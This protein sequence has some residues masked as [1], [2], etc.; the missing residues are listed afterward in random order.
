MLKKPQKAQKKKP[1]ELLT[2]QKETASEFSE[3]AKE[4]FASGENKKY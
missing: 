4:T 2:K 1:K 3:A